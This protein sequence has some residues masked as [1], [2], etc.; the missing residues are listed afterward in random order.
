MSLRAITAINWRWAL[1]LGLGALVIILAAAFAASAAPRPPRLPAAADAATI[2]VEQQRSDPSNIVFN[3]A[4]VRTYNILLSEEGQTQLNANPTAEQYVR[5]A[6]EIDGE[7]IEPVGTRYKGFYGALRFCF[8]NGQQICDKLSWKLKF[9]HYEPALRHHGLKRLNFHAMNN[10][11]TQ[12][13]EVLSYEVYRDAGVP[14]PRS[15]H[16]LLQLNGEPLGLYALTEDIDDIFIADRF[17]DRGRGILYKEIWPAN[18]DAL[19]GFQG[20]LD[21]AIARGPLDPSGMQAFAAAFTAAETNEQRYA[22]LLDQLHEAD[23][24]FNY[25]AVDRLIDNWDGIV[26][27]YC[28]P[29]C[30]N[31]NFFWYEDAL[32]DGFTLIPWDLEHTWRS[33]SPIRTA[34][35]MPDWDELERSCRTRQVFFNIPARA[36]HC[37]PLINTLATHGWERYIEASRQLL[38]ET[39]SL[40]LMHERVKRIGERIGE[41]VQNADNGPGHFVWQGAVKRLYE[42]IGERWAYIDAKIEAWDAS[43][44]AP[45]DG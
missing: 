33:P 13:R 32:S 41:H 30:G 12:M 37:D 6:V 36:P 5:A 27:W 11:E 8:Q 20:S 2:G 25:L 9:N 40:E 18:I 35:R 7:L 31:H 24:L 29:E 15:V 26:A 16:A 42:E 38:H 23:N 17:R 43:G 4:T 44:K 22:V 19:W 10:D 28:V 45:G 3:P 21:D 34:Y 1:V 14:A 39:L